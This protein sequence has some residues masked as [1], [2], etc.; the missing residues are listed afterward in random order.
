MQYQR[1]G[2][3]DAAEREFRLAVDLSPQ[4][5]FI[6]EN[7]GVHYRLRGRYPEAE[8]EFRQ[9]IDLNPAYST[10][11]RELGLSYQAGGQYQAA[12]DA[13][14]KY[15]KIAANA[16]DVDFVHSLAAR[17]RQL[18]ERKPPTLRR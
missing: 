1:Q 9:I 2:K 7:L 5:A 6:R 10:A 15:L 16:A 18:A 14:D 12:A 8:K 3:I 17:N 4:Q 13:F 11:Y